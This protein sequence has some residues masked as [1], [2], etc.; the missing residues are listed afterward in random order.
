[1]ALIMLV[2]TGVLVAM[3][4][5]LLSSK[6]NAAS[7]AT[8]EPP[9]LKSIIMSLD[10]LVGLLRS[11]AG[12][13]AACAQRSSSPILTL[14]IFGRKTYVVKS[15]SLMAACDR[16]AK[17][18][19]FA[20]FVVGY[21]KRLLSA[22]PQ[23]LGLLSED[24]SEERG[25]D[26]LR[27]ATMQA[28]HKALK[29]GKDLD[30]LTASF[31]SHLSSCLDQA[32]HEL[33]SLKPLSMF[34]WV[35]NL[36]A[37]ASTDTM[38]GRDLNPM[39]APGVMDAFWTVD[40]NLAWLGLDVIPS[41]IAPN[42]NR[43]RQRLF[44]AFREYYAV[45]GTKAAA[46]VIQERHR[47]NT[48]HGVNNADIAQFELGLLV[49]LIINTRA[50][51]FWTLFYIYSDETL[52]RNIRTVVEATVTP[53]NPRVV[54]LAHVIEKIPVV[55]SLVQ[56]VIRLQSNSISGRILLEDVVIEDTDGHQY[57]L[58]K[59][60]FLAMPSM[61]VH[62]DDNIWGSMAKDFVPERFTSG[63]KRPRVPASSNRGFGGGNAICPG[64]HFATREIIS[65]LVM[66]AMRFDIRPCTGNWEH[67]KTFHRLSASV[68][69]PIDDI[70]I[71]IQP[72]EGVT[73]TSW[74]FAWHTA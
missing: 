61:V 5:H 42:S 14:E 40:G 38:Y 46:H 68:T 71:D 7:L 27:P 58:K 39:R 43:C 41:L 8:M 45:N 1:M 51:T 69:T 9:L 25:S 35:Q 63:F 24:M 34:K 47:I 64:R 53:G 6:T 50:A 12:Y 10:H 44:A 52:L 21:A 23:A 16:R 4:Y 15:P 70:L 55:E 37:S 73:E 18:I 26:C 49:A 57:L 74:E 62:H 66:V 11:G 32:A 54:N 60:A 36:V 30:E 33:D 2:L 20:P 65:I 31:I 67:P 72:R 59:D 29:P 17:T 3:L 56:E 19:S 13:Y 48:T 28:M 22:S